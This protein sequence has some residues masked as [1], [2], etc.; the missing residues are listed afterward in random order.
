MLSR[1]VTD[2]GWVG[3]LHSFLLL[4]SLLLSIQVKTTQPR[5]Y[6]VRPNQGLIEPGQ[7]LTVQIILVEKDKNQLLQSY[8]SLGGQAALDQ[9][10]KDKFL[11]QSVAIVDKTKAA[12]LKEYD[13]LT[14]LWSSV[15]SNST[16]SGTS[17]VANK[18]LHVRH[19]VVGNTAPPVAAAA[20][21][22]PTVDGMSEAQLKAEL[23]PLRRKYDELVTFSVNLT[24]ERDMLSNTLDH[25]KMEL[26]RAQK[27]IGTSSSGG[28]GGVSSLVMIVLV[29]VALVLGVKLQHSGMLEDIPVVQKLLEGKFDELM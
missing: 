19:S 20:P 10:S 17:P 8:H 18:K 22:R 7:S 13:N 9:H 4:F 27:K 21:N 11:V 29:L 12:S 2:S 3:L 1:S 14:T 26:Q 16:A 28:G 15:A 5:R 6:L 23:T 24:T 25:T